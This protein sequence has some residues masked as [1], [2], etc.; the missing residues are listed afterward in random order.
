M[1]VDP[2]DKGKDMFRSEFFRE[3]KEPMVVRLKK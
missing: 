1:N 2:S 3:R